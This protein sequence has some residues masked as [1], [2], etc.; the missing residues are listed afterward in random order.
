MGPP[1]P[2]AL[3]LHSSTE[4]LSRRRHPN[5]SSTTPAGLSASLLPRSIPPHTC[6][7]ALR[8][9]S[10]TPISQAEAL[11]TLSVMGSGGEALGEQAGLDKVDNFTVGLPP[12]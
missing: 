5:P 6:A 12:M 2:P 8:T 11:P 7:A 1:L 3:H 10:C 4:G 9:G